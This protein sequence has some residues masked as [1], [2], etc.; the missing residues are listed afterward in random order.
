MSISIRKLTNPIN[1]ERILQSGRSYRVSSKVVPYSVDKDLSK[2][3]KEN[4]P[5]EYAHQVELGNLP[6]CVTKAIKK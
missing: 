5:G 6:P 1:A 3:L 4:F 2:Y